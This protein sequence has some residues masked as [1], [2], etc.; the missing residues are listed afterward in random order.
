MG[1]TW[2]NSG[3]FWILIRHGDIYAG[4]SPT[5]IKKNNVI[6]Y[7]LNLVAQFVDYRYTEF[8]LVQSVHW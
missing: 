2:N 8:A 3:T 7:I 1:K 5:R 4:T 6:N